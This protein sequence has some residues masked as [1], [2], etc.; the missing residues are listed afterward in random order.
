MNRSRALGIAIVIWI[1]SCAARH[2]TPRSAAMPLE[3]PEPIPEPVR[4]PTPAAEPPSA[5]AAENQALDPRVDPA[6]HRA[7]S[8]A[9]RFTIAWRPLDGTIP[10]NE[11]FEI[12]AYVYE[13]EQPVPDAELLVSGW[14]PEHGHGMVVKPSAVDAG[15]GR[16]RVSGMLLHMRG[17]WQLYFDVVK[18]GLSERTDFQLEIR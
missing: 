9:G 17:S 1:G 14:M 4:E 3:R 10:K 13:G 8:R 7:T 11:Y 12:E 18:D 6:F 2:E 16:Y 15:Q 5:P